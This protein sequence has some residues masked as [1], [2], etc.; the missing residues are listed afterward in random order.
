MIRVLTDIHPHRKHHV[1]TW[2]HKDT[3]RKYSLTASNV[4]LLALL[5]EV[6]D[7]FPAPLWAYSVV[8]DEA[9]W[10][11]EGFPAR[12]TSDVAGTVCYKVQEYSCHHR[13]T[14]KGHNTEK[15]R[16]AFPNLFLPRPA[17]HASRA[18]QSRCSFPISACF[19]TV[20]HCCPSVVFLTVCVSKETTVIDNMRLCSHGERVLTCS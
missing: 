18:A 3:N 1:Q 4:S 17:V 14:R 9:E 11:G 8:W 15:L 16:P 5:T 20:Q 2:H 6:W 13:H 10:V 19:H 12:E 7:H